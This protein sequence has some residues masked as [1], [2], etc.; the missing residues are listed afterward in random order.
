VSSDLENVVELF[1]IATRSVHELR[2]V[3]AHVDDV[4]TS[5]EERNDPAAADVRDALYHLREYWKVVI[6]R[7]DGD[8]VK[9]ADTAMQ[10]LAEVQV[11]DLLNRDPE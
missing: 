3:I 9:E 5:L 10:L 7:L 6:R 1:P 11:T 2:A 8:A 4:A